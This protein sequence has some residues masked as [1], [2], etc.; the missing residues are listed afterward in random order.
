MF[1]VAIFPPLFFFFFIYALT[2]ASLSFLNK[3]VDY[4]YYFLN[5]WVAVSKAKKDID[6]IMFSFCVVFQEFL[7]KLASE[8][9]EG[10][11]DSDSTSSRL[12]M[13]KEWLPVL[14]KLGKEADRVRILERMIEKF[15]HEEKE[16][17]LSFWLHHYATCANLPCFNLQNCYLR[18]YSESLNVYLK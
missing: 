11:S 12:S 5:S 2:V 13:V 16:N 4:Y 3:V 6:Y 17:V 14:C 15:T 1:A 8:E 9:L 7:F 10:D 18:W